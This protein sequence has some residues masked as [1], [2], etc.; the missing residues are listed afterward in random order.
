[1]SLL[2]FALGFF[3][4]IY[5]FVKCLL[6]P[7]NKYVVI[8]GLTLGIA[9]LMKFSTFLLAPL[10]IFLLI[11]FLI[12]KTKNEP[13]KGAVLKYLLKTVLIFI[14]GFALVYIIYFIFTFN[15]PI[16][17]QISDTSTI[18]QS[19][20]GGPD[21][22]LETCHLSAKIPLDRRLRC[23]AETN[24]LMTKNKILRP[25]AQYLLG[26]LMVMQRSTGGNTSYFLGEVSASGWWYYFPTVFVLK[27]PIP[28]LIIIALALI[29]AILNILK[30]KSYKLKA[31][32]NYL[33]TD[34]PSFA[35]ICFVILYWIYSIKS[36]LNIGIRHILPTL[37]FIYI[38][39]TEVI[40][41]WCSNRKIN[42][43]NI[44]KT[45]FSGLKKIIISSGKTII[46]T[47]LIIWFVIEIFTAYP[48]FLSYFNEFG[49]GVWN[50]YKYVTDSNYDWGQDLKRL[51]KLVEER[52][53]DNEIAN[54]VDKI[55][56][57]YFGGGDPKYYLKDKAVYWWSAK[58]N[59]KEE[60][61]NYLA[62]SI[63]TLQGA[64]GK[65][66]PGQTRKPEDEYQWLKAIRN[67]YEPDFKAGTSI[68][69][70]K[71]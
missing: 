16:Q 30:A 25:F 57:D 56:V 67:P 28:S 51:A 58:G 9:L 35:M 38:L 27:E 24:I 64:F 44:L 18:L 36:P 52:N 53:N 45:I 22:E 55:A 70:Y 17:K 3:L 8:S 4:A 66:H 69:I 31:I 29:I 59:P 11:V 39:S 1:M 68:F 10:F 60:G 49:G 34:F 12:W 13:E 20:A 7:K 33:G 15:Y 23:I 63:N 37:P 40:K 32:N 62:V 21:P 61:I 2:I 47:G 26:L 43:G 5:Y 41:N 46:L 65:L 14:I 42:R 50:G 71:L 19:F 54:D 48:Y 6:T